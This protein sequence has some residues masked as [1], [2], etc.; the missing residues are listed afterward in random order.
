[1]QWAPGCTSQFYSFLLPRGS[2][3]DGSVSRLTEGTTHTILPYQ[4]TGSNLGSEQG[5]RSL[6][7]CNETG[8]GGGGEVVE[9]LSLEIFK[10]RLDKVLC[11]LL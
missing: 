8:K 11:S 10:T 7:P 5:F 4:T 9:S 1:M 6:F 3:W 2:D